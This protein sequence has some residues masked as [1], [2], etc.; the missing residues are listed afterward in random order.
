MRATVLGWSVTESRN[1]T[2]GTRIALEVD[3]DDYCKQTAIQCVGN[4]CTQEYIRGDYSSMLEV[5]QSVQLVYG[6]GFQG[7]AVL[8]EIVPINNQ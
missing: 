1:K 8:Q 5:G 6:K 4:D 7:K 2:V 3:F